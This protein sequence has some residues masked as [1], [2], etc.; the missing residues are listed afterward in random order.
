MPMYTH[1]FM[2]A[3]MYTHILTYSRMYTPTLMHSP[4]YTPMLMYTPILICPCMCTLP[5][6][7][8]QPV[9]AA[10]VI[11]TFKAPTTPLTPSM[12]PKA[13]KKCGQPVKSSLE[14]SRPYLSSS[15][16]SMSICSSTSPSRS[17]DGTPPSLSHPRASLPSPTD[18]RSAACR[19]RGEGP[20]PV[21][22]PFLLVLPRRGRQQERQG[23]GDREGVIPSQHQV[24]LLV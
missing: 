22:T 18:H 15:S 3:R 8:A 4:M 5:S 17:V 16:S 12:T 1:T 20:R 23:E 19:T 6:L 2:Y 7:A 11:P 10:S 9:L 14:S 24:T 21:L 13:R